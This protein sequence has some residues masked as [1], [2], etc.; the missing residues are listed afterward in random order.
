MPATWWG[1]PEQ[2]KLKQYEVTFVPKQ[3]AY[4]EFMAGFDETTV[5]AF[6]HDE[7]AT[8]ANLSRM[9]TSFFKPLP[10]LD[11]STGAHVLS[12]AQMFG[13]LWVCYVPCRAYCHG[14]RGCLWACQIARRDSAVAEVSLSV[15]G[16]QGY[17]EIQM[18]G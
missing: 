18:D 14:W 17:R 10:F 12:G 4:S 7:K 1:I 13:S 15:L 2:V 8:L 3:F 6:K 11:P 5:V 9:E 16:E